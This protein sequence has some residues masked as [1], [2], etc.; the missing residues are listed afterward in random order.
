MK[1][2]ERATR[3]TPSGTPVI[4]IDDFGVPCQTVTR[5]EVWE[6]GDGSPVVLLRG[7]TGGFILERV[8]VLEEM[9]RDE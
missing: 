8:F 2:L 3:E 9:R 7:R 5:S 1:K 4:Y 6:L